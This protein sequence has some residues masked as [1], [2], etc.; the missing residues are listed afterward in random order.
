MRFHLFYA[1]HDDWF[2]VRTQDRVWHLLH[3]QHPRWRTLQL[4]H[5]RLGSSPIEASRYYPDLIHLYFSRHQ[6]AHQHFRLLVSTPALSS[7]RSAVLKRRWGAVELCRKRSP[8]VRLP[9]DALALFGQVQHDFPR[10]PACKS[11]LSAFR[12]LQL[13][14]LLTASAP[15]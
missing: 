12:N 11:E 7:R 10:A 6:T 5:C 9:Q 1:Q 14:L 2:N 8:A 13:T 15:T 4:L 3:A